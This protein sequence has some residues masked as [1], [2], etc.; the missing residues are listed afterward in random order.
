MFGLQKRNQLC[1]TIIAT[2]RVFLDK[3]GKEVVR[4]LANVLHHFPSRLLPESKSSVTIISCA[5]EPFKQYRERY[6]KD[7]F[8]MENI[9]ELLYDPLPVLTFVFLLEVSADSI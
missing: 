7:G 5:A 9:L 1:W 6:R 3:K 8:Q 2:G 4:M